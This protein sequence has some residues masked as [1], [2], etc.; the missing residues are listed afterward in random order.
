MKTRTI[1]TSLV[2]LILLI[3][4]CQDKIYESF[5]ANS[6]VYLTYEELRSA[7]QKEPVRDIENPGKIYF[8]DNYLF[9]NETMK[10][11]HVIDVSDLV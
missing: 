3:S 9:V 4:G 6:P 11:V 5:M 1:Y 2:F 10:G 7:V 8:K